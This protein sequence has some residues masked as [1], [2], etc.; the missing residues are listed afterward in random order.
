MMVKEELA[1]MEQAGDG[2]SK[3]FI[4]LS[5]RAGQ[6]QDQMG[7]TRQRIQ[8]LSSDTRGLDTAMGLGRGLAGGFSAATSC[9]LY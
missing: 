4:N 5:V 8:I 7:D 2:S 1:R 9:Q 3:A 6:L